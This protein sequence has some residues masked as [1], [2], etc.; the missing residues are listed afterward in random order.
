MI[1]YFAFVPCII[2][3][4]LFLVVR[5]CALSSAFFW[6]IYLN[7]SLVHFK[8][9][10]QYYKGDSQDIYPFDKTPAAKF[11]FEKLCRFFEIV[12][13]YFFFHFCF[14]DGVHFQYSQVLLIFLF[15]KHSNSLLIRYFYSFSYLSFSTSHY[16]HGIFSMPNSISLYWLYILIVCICVSNSFSFLAN[17]LMS[18]MSI[19]W[20][21]FSCN[22]VNLYPPRNYYYSYYY[23]YYY[24]YFHTISY[25]WFFTKG[26]EVYSGIEEFSKYP[27]QFY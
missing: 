5:L 2:C 8:N 10:S 27:N 6:S 17:S 13:C 12:F 24:Y 4:R 21:I 16:Q 1:P 19:R 20:L 18:S 25:L 11:D 7:C 22:L 15:S 14:S 9:R 3:L 26:K 23:Y